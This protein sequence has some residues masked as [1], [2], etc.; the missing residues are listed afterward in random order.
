MGVLQDSYANLNTLYTFSRRIS[1]PDSAK[2][3]RTQRTMALEKMLEKILLHDH[4]ILVLLQ[5]APQQPAQLDVSMIA[6]AARNIM[7]TA[8]LYFHI[9]K[10]GLCADDLAFRGETLVLNKVCN[11]MEI[12]KKLGF[13]QRCMRAVLNAWYFSSAPQRFER[14][15]AF[16]RLSKQ[17]KNQV[18]SGRKPGFQIQ[19]PRIL[20]PQTESALYNLL[21]NSVHALPLGLS[22][23]SV[24]ETCLF[25]S[26]FD[27]ER[28]L[29]IALQISCLYTAHVV[30][31]YLELR[32]R[33][34]A[35]LTQEEKGL[36]KSYLC[37]GNLE[38]YL[39][40]LRHA[41]E[42]DPF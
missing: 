10:R 31:D 32:R 30:K 42:K 29:T 13:S 25:H 22:N 5:P 20:Q 15:A 3:A 2:R 19:P 33:F 38:Q 40:A 12:T 24:N 21:S 23:N 11:E 18:V 14:F 34:Y 37:A 4:C 7:E 6:S 36:L 26:F 17:E 41:Y 39:D 9:A 8:N 35:L 27:A 16:K 28:L 1:L